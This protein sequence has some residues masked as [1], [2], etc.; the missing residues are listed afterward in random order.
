MGEWVNWEMEMRGRCGVVMEVNQHIQVV[1]T[2][3]EELGTS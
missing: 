2:E 3:V 1:E